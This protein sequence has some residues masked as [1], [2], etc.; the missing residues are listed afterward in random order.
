[1]IQKI[2]N[3]LTKTEE[4][5]SLV[6][7]CAVSMVKKQHF[8]PLSD[9]KNAWGESRHSVTFKRCDCHTLPH[10]LKKDILF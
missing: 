9:Y 4:T 3:H 2:Q 10:H 8:F 6:S 1:M 7:Y 5:V